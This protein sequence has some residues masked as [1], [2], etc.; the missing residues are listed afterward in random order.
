V[1]TTKDL[2]FREAV[3]DVTPISNNSADTGQAPIRD[4]SIA[5]RRDAATSN[6]AEDNYLSSSHMQQLQPFDVV[7]FKRDGVQD[8]VFR[9][10]K[11]G[12]YVCDASLD[13]H[14]MTIDQA[15]KAVL[16]FIREACA[17][18]LRTVMITH[19]KGDRSPDKKAVLKSYCVHWLEQIPEVLA[20]HSAL[21]QQGGTGAL[22]ILLKKSEAA[23]NKNREILGIK[24]D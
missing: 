20:F 14:R 4:V 3:A 6:V 19:G 7:S 11:Q 23:K 24:Y 1:T 22:Y 9:K 12:K 18:D 8:G 16:D 15:C 2:H 17:Y 21:N 13:L 10:L 5:I